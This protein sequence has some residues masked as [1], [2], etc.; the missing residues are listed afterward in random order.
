MRDEARARAFSPILAAALA[1][2][3]A[4]IAPAEAATKVE[5]AYTAIS[6][7]FGG[8]WV[9]FEAGYF[10]RHGLDVS[11]SYVASSTRMAQAMVAGEQPIAVMGGEAAI[12]AVLGGGDLVFVAGVL[13]RPLFFMV[14]APD[15]QRPED[16]RGKTLGVTLLGASSDY[17]TRLALRHWGLEPIRDV[18]I[19]QIGGIPEILSA[20]RAGTVKGGALSPPTNL[21]ARRE[22][23]RELVSTAELGFFPHDAIVTPRSFLRKNEKVVRAYLMAYAEGVR[24]YKADRPYAIEVLRRYTKVS[25]PELLEQ[26]HALTS[27]PLEEA[28]YLEPKALQAVLDVSTHPKAKM[29]KPEDFMDLRILREL[30]QSGFFKALR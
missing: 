8:Q 15:I 22:G 11:L 5:S 14:V 13:N 29:A 17:A 16:L 25:D 7:V 3:A 4:A 2:A 1:A 30:E 9:A 10:A 18:G 19:V 20:M 27:A 21:R 23:F 12:H 6:G 28:L 26:T 24:R